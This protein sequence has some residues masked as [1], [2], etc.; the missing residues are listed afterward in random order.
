MSHYRIGLEMVLGLRLVRG[1][2]IVAGVG[3]AGVGRTKSPKRIFSLFC[4][5][6]I[7]GFGRDNLALGFRGIICVGSGFI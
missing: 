4:L 7:S 6:L 1:R 2:M 5:G 3:G